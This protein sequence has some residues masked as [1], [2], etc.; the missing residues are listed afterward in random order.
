[1]EMAL[2]AGANTRKFPA[3]PP[4]Y[5]AF[6]TTRIVEKDAAKVCLRAG[7]ATVEVTVLAPDLFRVGLFPH[8]RSISYDSEAVITWEREAGTVTILEEAGELT[9]AT[10]MATAHLSLDPLRINFTDQTGRSF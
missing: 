8:G 2:P 5:Q 9:I 7:S 3:P 4:G 6:G 10:A 1:M